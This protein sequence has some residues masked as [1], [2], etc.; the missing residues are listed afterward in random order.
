V[1]HTEQD[2]FTLISPLVFTEVHVVLSFVSLISCNCHVFWILS[3]DC[4]FCLI[5]WYIYLYIFYLCDPVL[6]VLTVYFELVIG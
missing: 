1:P 2:M 6:H 5:A 4:S 3:F